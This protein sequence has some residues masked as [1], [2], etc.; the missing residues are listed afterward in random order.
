MAWYTSHTLRCRGRLVAITTR[1][2]SPQSAR[3][4]KGAPLDFG[5][6]ACLDVLWKHELT[7]DIKRLLKLFR[8]SGEIRREISE[9]VS[10][11]EAHG[12]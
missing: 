10:A 7:G 8:R 11:L 12:G 6:D 3:V 5:R 9:F 1:Y 4:V 2:G